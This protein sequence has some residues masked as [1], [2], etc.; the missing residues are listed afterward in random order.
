MLAARLLDFTRYDDALSISA[1]STR[2]DAAVDGLIPYVWE[3]VTNSPTDTTHF[4]LDD[5]TV[6]RS[7]G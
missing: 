3:I 5:R 7:R 4:S 1:V 6:R 2:V